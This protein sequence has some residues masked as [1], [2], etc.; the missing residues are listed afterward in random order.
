MKT[1]IWWIRRDLRIQHNPALEEAIANSD[2]V[3]PLYIL[4]PHLLSKKAPRRLTFLFEAIASLD[5]TLRQR[6]SQL[7]IKSGDPYLVLQEVMEQTKAEAVFAEADYSP[8]ARQRDHKIAISLPLWLV[9]GLTVFP[10]G[11]VVKNT[12]CPYTVFSHFNRAWKAL[13]LPATVSIHDSA[14]KLISTN[15]ANLA[16]EP[17]PDHTPAKN[18]P[19]SEQIANQQLDLFFDAKL[20]QYAEKRDRMDLDGT[21]RLSPYLRFGLI[22]PH[23][24]VSRAILAVEAAKDKKVRLSAE[25]W[26][27]E[28]IWRE[29]Y[30]SILHYFPEVLQGSFRK[31][32]RNI[33]WR[34][35]PG[36][37]EQWKE[38]MTGYPVVDAGMRELKQS[39]WMHNRARMITASFLVKDL[40]INWQEGEA[41][42]MENLLDGDP[43]TNNGGWQW[44][45]GV[46]TD[47]A[48][49]FRIF[50]PVLQGEKFD[51][52]GNYI[53]EW[54]PELATVPDEFIHKP[55]LMSE[56]MQAELGIRIGE[57]YPFPMVDHKEV[58]NRALAAYSTG[59]PREVLDGCPT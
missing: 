6:G 37:F 21:S 2:V 54:I 33:Q 9:H 8:Y 20:N 36:D 42:F 57:Q 30:I 41:W 23:Y 51:P 39:G 1:S 56:K 18:F 46:G 22:S 43:A 25:T 32:L 12:G 10:P 38:G 50:N 26:L 49:F 27:D 58:K 31:D 59:K 5:Q 3:L 35:A 45:S 7:W 24:T 4:D 53:R 13:P 28:L 55:W 52:T 16:S 19:A 17:I 34:N 48:P 15:K 14:L 11:V 44:V 29:F 47:A 40:L